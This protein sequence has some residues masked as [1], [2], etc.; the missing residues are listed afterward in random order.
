MREASCF[1]CQPGLSQVPG[2]GFRVSSWPKTRNLELKTRNCHYET[3]SNRVLQKSTV[4]RPRFMRS[5]N[6]ACSADFQSA[7]S[8][9]FNL[10][11]KRQVGRAKQFLHSADC[12]SAI[13]QSA[14]LRYFGCGAAALCDP[15]HPWSVVPVGRCAE[16]S[17]LVKPNQARSRWIKPN[18]GG[19]TQRDGGEGCN[20][21]F[22]PTGFPQAARCVTTLAHVGTAES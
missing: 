22:R 8:Q 19:S 9:V 4:L 11:G 10:R 17:N 7:V 3:R 12:K 21:R 1:N 20:G 2:S 14:T 6:H 16:Q 15:R 18:Q 13:Q 5:I